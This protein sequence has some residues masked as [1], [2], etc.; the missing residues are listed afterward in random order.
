MLDKYL[1][2]PTK[3]V[4]LVTWY[5]CDGPPSTDVRL[6][7]N[8][9]RHL[10]GSLGSCSVLVQV[11]VDGGC[12]FQGVGQRLVYWI[13]NKKGCAGHRLAGNSKRL[14]VKLKEWAKVNCGVI[15]EVKEAIWEKIQKLDRKE[16]G[17][18]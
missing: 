2:L 13:A 12:W 15:E 4:R 8:F 18:T 14:R 10:M 3:Q 7:S 1:V 16:H 6:L 17:S 5:Y 11:C 9:S